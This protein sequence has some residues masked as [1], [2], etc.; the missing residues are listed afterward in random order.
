MNKLFEFRCKF[1]K[2]FPKVCYFMFWFFSISL[3]QN[4]WVNAKSVVPITIKQGREK[5]LLFI[6]MIE[7]SE[8][9]LFFSFMLLDIYYTF[10]TIKNHRLWCFPGLPLPGERCSWGWLLTFFCVEARW[11]SGDLPIAGIRRGG[12]WAQ[13]LWAM[14]MRSE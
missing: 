6:Y 1:T 5:A 7:C 8:K 10:A 9:Y 14:V 2:T 11:W 13:R 4:T 3:F 12:V